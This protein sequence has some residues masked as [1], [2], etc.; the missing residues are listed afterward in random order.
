MKKMTLSYLFLTAATLLVV[1]APPKARAAAGDL[2]EADFGSGSVFKFTPAGIKSTFANGLGNPA[3]VAFDPKGNL[4]VSDNLHGLIIKITPAGVKSTFASGLNMPFGV[5]FDANGNLYEAD[6]GSGSVFRFTPAGAKT[7]FASGFSTPAGLAFDPSGNLFISNFTGG[8]I[9][10]I[11]PGGARSAF[12]SGLSFPNGLFVSPFGNL[13]ECDS[14][15]GNVFS[16]TPAGVKTTFAGG[17]FQNPGVIMDEAGNAFVTQNAAGTIIKISSTGARTT[18]AAGLFNPQYLAF[19]PALGPPLSLGNIST[20]GLV[21]TGDQVLIGGIIIQGN[22]GKRVIIRAI[23]PSLTQHG[24]AGALQDPTL[25][26]HDHT[27]ALIGQNDN[28]RTTEIG[29]VITSDQ[30]AAIQATH[31]APSDNRES[32]IIATLQPGSYTAIVRGKNNTTGIALVEAY[33]LDPQNGARLAEI[34]TRGFVQTGDNVMIGG[35]ILTQSGSATATVL[36]RAI[37]PE[38]TQHHVPNALQNPT[39]ELHN[40]NGALIASNDDWKTNQ[41]QIIAATGLAPTDDRESAIFASL[42]P[43]N[44][45]AI[46]RGENS[47]TGNALVE[48]YAL[49]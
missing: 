22:L 36:I 1:L 16:Y 48:V 21:Q 24:V 38:L 5:A 19:E 11:A 28:W 31:L 40:G 30:V 18:F 25:E 39:L 29:G 42:S 15:S 34:S 33:D 23:G 17:F 6:E 8:R 3:G 13:L 47:S 49:Q 45:T 41:E 27:G 10:K 9:D 35:F 44:Y 20:R 4:F 37:G 12:A 43:G 32:A 46:V 2:Y 14:G 26:L 7:T